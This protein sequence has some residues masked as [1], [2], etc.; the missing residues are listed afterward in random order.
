M[1]DALCV[2]CVMCCAVVVSLLHMIGANIAQVAYLTGRAAGVER[3][4]FAGNFLRRNLIS[5]G[6][7]ADSIS[8]WSGGAMKALF[9]KHEGMCRCAVLCCAVLL[10]HSFILCA[11]CRLLR[12]V[13]RAAIAGPA[14]LLSPLP[15]LFA[16]HCT[17]TA[18]RFFFRLPLCTRV[19]LCLCLRLCFCFCF[20]SGGHHQLCCTAS[21]VA[22]ICRSVF[23]SVTHRTRRR[24]CHTPSRPT[25]I[26]LFS[27]RCRCCTLF[28]LHLS[29]STAVSHQPSKR[30]VSC[31]RLL[32][33]VVAVAQ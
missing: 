29:C 31:F 8:Y 28:F 11:V 1:C 32:G 25:H 19:C 13:G 15:P 24:H 12:F 16:P 14:R 3:I 26:L 23:H 6:F 17:H 9:L 27:C 7:L 20:C 4:L 5:S 10:T 18:R 22:H 30:C 21:A 33:A 2:L